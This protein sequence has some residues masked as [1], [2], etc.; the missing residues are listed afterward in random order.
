MNNLKNTCVMSKVNV[1]FLSQP[2]TPSNKN[3]L[4]SQRWLDRASNKRGKY[5]YGNDSFSV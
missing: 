5:Y 4:T 1:Q 3:K 2:L